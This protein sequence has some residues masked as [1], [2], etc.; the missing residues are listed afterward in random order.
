MYK[1]VLRDLKEILEAIPEVAVVSLGKPRDLNSET[2]F[3][4]LY[5]N[6]LSG[7]YD[8][9]KN[10]KCLNGYDSYELVRVIVNMECHDELDFLDLRD[11]I[12][13][14]VLD[15]SAIWKVIVDRDL[16]NWTNDDF[17]NYPKKQFEVGFE[18]RLRA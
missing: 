14:A 5:I 9:N 15:D 16:V 13:N 12:I 18:F 17:D 7:V 6:P 3:P 2:V 11:S 10:T 4:T 8:N 1:N